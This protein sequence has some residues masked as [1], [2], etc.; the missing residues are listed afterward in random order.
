MEGD[1]VIYKELSYRINSLLF[2]THRALGRYRNEK[3][4]GDYFERLLKEKNIRYIREFK[5]VDNDFGQGRVRC[6]CDFIVEDKIILEFKAKD[7]V[8]KDDYYQVMR[9]LKTLD[10]KLA[11]LVNF[12]QPRIVPKR[13]LN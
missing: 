7:H 9:Y 11:V 5:F 13:I 4:Y 10:L 12:R 8:S 2:T 6:V 3:Q 1:K